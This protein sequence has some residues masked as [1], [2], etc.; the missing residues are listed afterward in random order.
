[1]ADMR[2]LALGETDSFPAA[3]LRAR[4]THA[5]AH[6][7][8]A[9][10][11]HDGRDVTFRR[12]DDDPATV[13]V[14]PD[15]GGCRLVA[16]PTSAPT[17]ADASRIGLDLRVDGSQAE[18]RQVLV[19]AVDVGALREHILG[20]LDL[21]DGRWQL[22]A[23]A[24]EPVDPDAW[25]LGLG[26][27]GPSPQPFARLDELEHPWLSRGRYA[28]RRATDGRTPPPVTGETWSLL[29][30]ASASI[31]AVLSP[32]RLVALAELTA[33]I[34]AEQTGRL[35]VGVAGTGRRDEVGRGDPGLPPG[36]VVAAALAE[37]APSWSI[38][39]DSVG[40]AIAQGSRVVLL[41]TDGPP[42]DTHQLAQL[43]RARTAV[44]LLVVALGRSAYSLPSD[45]PAGSASGVE[46]LGALVDLAE[47]TNVTLTAVAVEGLDDERRAAEL[48]AAL[49][50]RGAR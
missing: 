11:D 38:V 3:V 41:L 18:A 21:A 6:V 33:G 14:S 37:P 12:F 35:P 25:D 45:R 7:R 50:E 13:L 39:A 22:T 44:R 23:G 47:L 27:G 17:F 4:L 20:Q 49:T 46:E 8:L 32:E 31:R 36:D 16:T 2:E 9:A 5:P 1:M 42:A 10:V 26:G 34:L 29:V 28:L 19:D 43:L 48:A 24:A 30:D 40:I 15:R